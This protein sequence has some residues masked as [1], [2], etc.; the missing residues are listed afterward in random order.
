MPVSTAPAMTARISRAASGFR[1]LRMP[2]ARCCPPKGTGL[3]RVACSGFSR[4]RISA[5]M[6]RKTP[7]M[8]M[9]MPLERT[10][11][12]SKPMVQLMN[13]RESSPATVVIALEAMRMKHCASASV[14]ASFAQS[15]SSRQ[16]LYVCSSMMA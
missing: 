1:A 12:I 13:S 15:P 6:N 14:T 9:R 10:T 8:L 4:I 16:A 7:S 2:A 5:G 3:W 11:P